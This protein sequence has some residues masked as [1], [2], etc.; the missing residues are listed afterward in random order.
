MSTS[1]AILNPSGTICHTLTGWPNEL[2]TG[3]PL[4]V[5]DRIPHGWDNQG[6]TMEHGDAKGEALPDRQDGH[7]L[8][9]LVVVGSNIE[10]VRELRRI[11]FEMIGIKNIPSPSTIMHLPNLIK[12]WERFRW[13]FHWIWTGE[14]AT[15]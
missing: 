1:L 13:L 9:N 15:V 8:I 5:L 4:S 2:V 14:T 6:F 12:R 3:L 7:Y 11:M 10:D